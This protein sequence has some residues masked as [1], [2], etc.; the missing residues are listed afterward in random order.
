MESINKVE[1]QGYVGSVKESSISYDKVYNF[2]VCTCECGTSSNGDI[3]ITNT[4][5]YVRAL[6][7]VV[8]G[9]ITKGC[10]VHII[11]KLQTS[12]Y[13][14]PNNLEKISVIIIADKLDVK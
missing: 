3:F 1:I 14:T 11:G 6:G 5:H 12:S 2:S 13:I 10:T 8:N 4:W 9:D 7:K